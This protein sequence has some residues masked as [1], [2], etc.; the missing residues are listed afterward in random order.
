M[1]SDGGGA[2]M[3]PRPLPPERENLIQRNLRNK[4]CAYCKKPGALLK[5]E[6]C[7]QRSYCARGCQ[8]K[9][10]KQGHRGQCGKL[11]QVFVP[12]PAGWGEAA[13]AAGGGG[14][15]GAAAA[16]AAAGG[17]GSGTFVDDDGENLC[18]ICL[19]NED[20]AY[21]DGN[22]RGLCTACGQS[23]CGA[24]NAGG[25]AN[26]SPNCPTC[27]APLIVS[28]E[29]NFKRLWKLVH[30]RSPGRHTP[31]AQFNLGAMYSD[32]QGVKQDKK[33]AIK[34]YTLAAENDNAYAQF[35]LSIMYRD[36]EGVKQD[37][38]EAF[39]WCRL[40]TESGHAEAMALI[41]GM[42]MLGKG[43]AQD[44]S[45]GMHYLQRAAEKG[46]ADSIQALAKSQQD[47]TI[48]IPP[49]GA[50]VTMILL[51]SAAAATKYNNK[52]GVVVALPE[53]E[54]ALKVGRAAV[55]LEG[56]AK[57]ISFK[58][59]NLKVVQTLPLRDAVAPSNCNV[60]VSASSAGSCG[61][62]ATS[63]N[64][65][66]ADE[67]DENNLCP[68]CL[69][70]EDDAVVNKVPAGMCTAC[71]QCYCGACNDGKLPSRSPNCPACRAPFRVSEEE[72]F[73]RLWKLAHDKLPGRHT[74]AAQYNL[75]VMYSDGKGVQ[76]DKAEAFKW[77]KRA[78]EKGYAPAQ[79]NLSG[80]Y[81]DGKEVKQ[82]YNEAFKWCK[83]AAKSGH[84]GAMTVLGTMYVV[85]QGVAKDVS[86]G[87]YYLQRAAEKGSAGSI[88]VL[89]KLQQLNAISTPPP[90]T[91]I[92]VI[93][94]T[95]AAVAAKYNS[96]TGDVVTLPEGE[97]AVKVGRAAVLLE[98]EAKPTSFKL[99]NL[100][101]DP[102]PLVGSGVEDL[103]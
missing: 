91:R 54:P 42:Y 98:G 17:E 43:V 82:D 75:G 66:A 30:D 89:A 55:L 72:T 24:C 29:E 20:D 74:P 4:V 46:H 93:L 71:G 87:V 64:H 102:D 59:M 69:N 81:R 83:L 65:D 76:Q 9:D 25:L 73:K 26:K 97:P 48:A 78:A 62:S 99:M 100:R 47:N 31:G 51:T 10:W 68:I 52:R 84:I 23:Y 53:G 60:G 19:D 41:A 38:N 21:M 5:C 58:A 39:K 27:R 3:I 40:A 16:A 103:D 28:D 67:Q 61:G 77:Y 11:Q 7:R 36:G 2:T 33:E 34:W 92:T 95:S 35:N 70:N 45:K 44:Y 12:P 101:I 8:K 6:G 18:P 1:S 90:G 80:M 13:A 86:K 79:H 49:P 57:P 94:L 32:G 88:K 96:K 15:G 85:G 37:Y 22:R 50:H 56:E 63:G 14:G